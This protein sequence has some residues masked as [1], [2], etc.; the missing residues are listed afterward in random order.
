MQKNQ[1][2]FAKKIQYY[3]NVQLAPGETR[4][5]LSDHKSAAG[6]ALR[7]RTDCTTRRQQRL[8]KVS[9]GVAAFWTGAA[10]AIMTKVNAAK[11]SSS[12][13]AYRRRAL[14]SV[15]LSAGQVSPPGGVA[16]RVVRAQPAGNESSGQGLDTIRSQGMIAVFGRTTMF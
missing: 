10:R 16:P 2:D 11:R 14:K 1:V 8:R 7:I 13:V 12:G 6:S 5:M 3:P 15:R 9:E 4:P